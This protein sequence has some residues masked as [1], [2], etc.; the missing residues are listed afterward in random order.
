MKVATLVDFFD[1]LYP[2]A[3]AEEWDNVG[4]IVG[5]SKANVTGVLFCLDVTHDVLDEAIAENCNVLVT[6]HPPIF[7]ALKRINVAELQGGLIAKAIKHGIHLIALHTNLDSAVGGLND[8]LCEALGLVETKPLVDS[9][10]ERFY[11]LAVFVPPD[12][13]EKVRTALCAQG[14]GVI[15]DYEDCSFAIPGEGSFRG[16]EGKTTPFTGTPG[17][18][19]KTNELRL[20]LLL[21]RE[22]AGRVI[23][24]LHDAHPYEEVAYDLY[25]LHNKEKGTGLARIGKL[26]TPEPFRAFVGRVQALGIL[27]TRVLG[28]E[29]KAIRKVAL[30]SGAGADF[31]PNALSAGADVYLTAEIKHHLGLAA[32]H[33]GMALVETDHYTLERLHWPKLSK[34]IEQ[35][36]KDLKTKVSERGPE[37]WRRP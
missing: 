4:L 10:R 24:A 16:I 14:A 18:L 36:H 27:V 32:A 12:H 3:L 8:T 20:E 28:D 13:A 7:R 33:K 5:D 21:R 31:L 26:E 25:P 19:E 6:H 23:G 17:K 22:I 30:C 35:Q 11:K 9:G 2:F 1:R 29:S 37:L 34:L 15:G